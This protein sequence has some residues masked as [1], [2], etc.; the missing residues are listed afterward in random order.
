MKNFQNAGRDQH[1][2]E[3]S[4]SSSTSSGSSVARVA[5]APAA[6]TP[7]ELATW[8]GLFWQLGGCFG[9]AWLVLGSVRRL[10]IVYVHIPYIYIFL[11][12]Y[13]FVLPVGS[14]SKTFSSVSETYEHFI[15]LRPG[16]LSSSAYVSNVVGRN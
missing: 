5:S 7:R 10:Y 16:C 4:S 15:I 9:L 13:A 11:F 8:E 14:T 6:E 12:F 1:I 2:L 3:S